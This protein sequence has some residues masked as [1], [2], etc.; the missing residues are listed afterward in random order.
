MCF[1]PYPPSFTAMTFTDKTKP[2]YFLKVAFRWNRVNRASKALLN[3]ITRS[4]CPTGF[5][6][7]AKIIFHDIHA[8]E[9]TNV[10]RILVKLAHSFPYRKL[11]ISTMF[12]R[13]SSIHTTVFLEVVVFF[14]LY[15]PSSSASWK[16]AFL[17]CVVWSGLGEKH[18]ILFWLDAKWNVRYELGRPL[19][20]C[21]SWVGCQ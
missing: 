4:G 14:D 15:G 17:D 6:S 9:S 11:L 8:I 3:Y 5:C 20:I 2:K 10:L 21:G 13:F 16:N 12:L 19:V 18:N 1:P 7:A